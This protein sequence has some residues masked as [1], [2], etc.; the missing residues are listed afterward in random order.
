MSKKKR[1]KFFDAAIVYGEGPVIEVF[2][3]FRDKKRD[4][5]KRRFEKKKERF[6]KK[7]REDTISY[8]FEGYLNTCAAGHLYQEGKIKKIIVTGGKTGYEESPS[9]GEIMA[10]ILQKEFKVPEGDIIIEDAASNTIENAVYTIDTIDEN[11]EKYKNIVS[12]AAAH[13]LERTEILNNLLGIDA[14]YLSSEEIL[15]SPDGNPIR[16]KP[17]ID[18]IYKKAPVYEKR[19][20][21]SKR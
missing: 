3:G 14:K 20:K 19:G 10:K 9:E 21:E 15:L 4:E 18:E 17:Y 8:R 11:P 5:R 16:F 12:I 2:K 6:E 7:T 13:H 1:R